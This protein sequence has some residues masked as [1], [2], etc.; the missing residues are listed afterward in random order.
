[1]K[2]ST[3][4]LCAA[5]LATIFCTPSNAASGSSQGRIKTIQW[6]EGHTG[7]LIAQDNMS[8]LGGCG[9]SDYYILDSQHPYFKEIYSLLLAAHM[10]DQSVSL[11]LEG[12][13]QGMS[14][15]KHVQSTR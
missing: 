6:F 1:M 4:A 13:L 3:L 12:C 9:R 10:S 7:A 11:T 14:R 5:I 8:D 15:I 2:A